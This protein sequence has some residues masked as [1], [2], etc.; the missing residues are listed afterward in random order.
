MAAMDVKAYLSSAVSYSH[1]SFMKLTPGVDIV[2][3]FSL[4]LIHGENEVEL[5]SQA[6]FFLSHVCI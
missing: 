6:R 1:K 2:R 4:L 3:L 5:L